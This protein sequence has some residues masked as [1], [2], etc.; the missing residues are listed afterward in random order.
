MGSNLLGGVIPFTPL[1]Q[2][3]DSFVTLVSRLYLVFFYAEVANLMSDYYGGYVKYFNETKLIVNW[4]KFNNCDDRIIKRINNYR[5]MVWKKCKGIDNQALI[6]DMPEP[7]RKRIQVDILK[8]VLQETR[9]LPKT[10]SGAILSLIQR[11]PIKMYPK[12][13]FIIY[14]GEIILEMY[15]II[16][17]VAELLDINNQKI[18]TLK[19]GK[20]FGEDTILKNRAQ[21]MVYTI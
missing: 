19:K 2:F 15:F 5:Q 16:K 17:G 10:D 1:E 18:G 21:R 20:Y 11:M 4:L 7:I 14:E 8:N 6:N 12:G 3:Y 9:I 13:E